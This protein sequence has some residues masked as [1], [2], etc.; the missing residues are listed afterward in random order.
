[1]AAGVL[2]VAAKLGVKVPE[3]LSV[4]GCDDIS[5]AQQIY[6]SLT[7]IRQPLAAM[8]ELA[9]LR[10]I[11]SAGQ[12]SPPRGVEV[13]PGTIEIRESTGPAPG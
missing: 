3:Q 5:L 1:M 8:A 10:I 2:R 13:V 11:D 9:A 6:P 7:T 12:D 4:V